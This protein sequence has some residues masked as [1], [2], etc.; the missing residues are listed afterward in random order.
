V[1]AETARLELQTRIEKARAG[2]DLNL[3]RLA[4]SQ[5]RLA[6]TRIEITGGRDERRRLHDCAYARLQAR[7]DSLPVI[8]QAKGILMARNGCPPTRRS[9]SL[10]V[11]W[12]PRGR[13]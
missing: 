2:L 11:L 7:L 4:E 1:T 13:R 9:T 8:E 12:P 3:Q 10:L 6:A 5:S